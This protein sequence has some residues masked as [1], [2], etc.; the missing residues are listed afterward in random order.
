MQ[1]LET[2]IVLSDVG[3]ADDLDPTLFNPASVTLQRQR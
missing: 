2:R 1:S 3:K